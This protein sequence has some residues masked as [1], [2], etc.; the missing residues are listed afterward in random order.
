MIVR[1]YRSDELH[2]VPQR[3]L[4]RHKSKRIQPSSRLFPPAEGT[5]EERTGKKEH[6]GPAA[7]G[8][9]PPHISAPISFSHNNHISAPIVPPNLS[10]KM[11][12]LSDST[13]AF[14][15][16]LETGQGN[17]FK[18]STSPSMR[19][20]PNR[21]SIDTKF[22]GGHHRRTTSRSSDMK[23]SH[24]SSGSLSRTNTIRSV[25]AQH[26]STSSIG[27]PQIPNVSSINPMMINHAAKRGSLNSSISS[28]YSTAST[29]SLSSSS[30]SNSSPARRRFRRRRTADDAS[31]IH[32]NSK[33]KGPRPISTSAQSS[34]SDSALP[35]PKNKAAN[36]GNVR[37]V[38]KLP[39]MKRQKGEN[40]A[41]LVDAGFFERQ[42][43]P[44]RKIHR[45]PVLAQVQ[46]HGPKG[47][48]PG[49]MV[50]TPTGFY[51]GTRGS[52]RLSFSVNPNRTSH[53]GSDKFKD[54]PIFGDEGEN[55]AAVLAQIPWAS[56][57]RLSL[58]PQRIS[59]FM[60]GVADEQDATSVLEGKGE[61]GSAEANLPVISVGRLSALSK[62]ESVRASFMAPAQLESVSEEAEEPQM[63]KEDDASPAS[64]PRDWPLRS[65]H[66]ASPTSPGFQ[67]LPIVGE[68]EEQEE[69]IL[70]VE[71]PKSEDD[72]RT[73]V[74]S[75]MP[76][77][78]LTIVA[79]V[80]EDDEDEANDG[81]AFSPNPDSP[82]IIESP[83]ELKIVAV[84]TRQ[85]LDSDLVGYGDDDKD[86]EDS[87]E[88]PDNRLSLSSNGTSTSH[89]S[90]DATSWEDA[91]ELKPLEDVK[92]EGE[93]DATT[94]QTNTHPE[95][96]NNGG[97]TPVVGKKPKR[98]T[99][100]DFTSVSTQDQSLAIARLSLAAV[101]QAASETFVELHRKESKDDNAD[102][103]IPLNDDTVLSVVP[104]EVQAWTQPVY[105]H[106][107]IR[108][109]RDDMLQKAS[110]A[111]LSFWHENEE[112]SG[113]LSS[114]EAVV[115]DIVNYFDSF[116]PG[117]DGDD[118]KKDRKEKESWYG[119]DDEK[120]N[121]QLAPLLDDKLIRQV[122]GFETIDEIVVVLGQD[123]AAKPPPVPP[124]P[125]PVSATPSSPASST[126]H[127]TPP[128]TPASPLRNSSTAPS[129]VSLTRSA[130]TRSNKPKVPVARPSSLRLLRR[131][132]F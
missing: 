42:N 95:H 46:D 125:R 101:P 64:R 8:A 75:V 98:M 80:T 89:E 41:Q 92:E 117:I 23:R 105:E 12:P 19:R 109:N 29:R 17:S 38:E 124:R 104:P 84:V 1:P 7:N 73:S 50:T 3:S 106:G 56:A 91:Q 111:G 47:D 26:R 97:V 121:W 120:E 86:E 59:S 33:R 76:S 108:L 123:K 81:L 58:F 87:L 25:K 24:G 110:M 88:L 83:K 45:L 99:M 51:D 103:N 93:E 62:R 43:L 130:T 72:L 132:I 2:D 15:G 63:S 131:G 127:I 102:Q 14:S 113:W 37:L 11:P 10:S 116:W 36:A 13:F 118:E 70:I 96:W 31:D 69:D 48:R 122:A 100:M 90:S 128:P 79:L 30:S 119:S 57:K 55:A 21:L 32:N 68:A 94:D 54:L 74:G 114:Q 61:N 20:T 60:Q 44:K 6:I 129:V 107:P 112:S 49:S 5:A 85:K 71:S 39:W 66:M 18:S 126:R 27:K 40:H 4:S 9:W 78:D 52:M 53:T 28:S 34:R 22:A 82:Q 115:D 35:A 65:S 67:I 77:S 16:D